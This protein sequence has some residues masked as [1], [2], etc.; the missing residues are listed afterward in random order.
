[1]SRIV[2]IALIDLAY[3]KAF[4]PVL[5][6]LLMTSHVKRGDVIY[7]PVPHPEAWLDTLRYVYTDTGKL[8]EASKANILYLAGRV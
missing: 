8:S 7:L 6:L 3:A 5:A 4:L 2:L 1:M